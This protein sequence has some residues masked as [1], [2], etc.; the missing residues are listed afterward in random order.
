VLEVL[1]A[2]EEGGDAFILFTL[3]VVGIFIALLVTISR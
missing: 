2:I 3:M 1:A